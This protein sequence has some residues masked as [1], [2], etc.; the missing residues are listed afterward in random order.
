MNEQNLNELNTHL[1]QK[2][3]MNS[4]VGKKKNLINY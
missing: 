1:E 3:S 2:D 4:T